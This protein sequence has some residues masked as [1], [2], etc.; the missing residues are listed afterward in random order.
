MRV[1][2][3]TAAAFA[4]AGQGSVVD[5]I[6]RSAG[7]NVDIHKIQRRSCPSDPLTAV[8]PIGYFNAALAGV[9]YNGG[10]CESNWACSTTNGCP[11]AMS[12]VSHYCHC[13]CQPGTAP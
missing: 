12:W 1:A 5:A 11:T 4:S 2:A 13:L 7:Y 6:N 9:N 10:G 3:A 8:C